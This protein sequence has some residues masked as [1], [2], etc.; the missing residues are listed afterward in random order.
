MSLV[1]D[2]DKSNAAHVQGLH[3]YWHVELRNGESRDQFADD[4]VGTTQEQSLQGIKM[5]RKSLDDPFYGTMVFLGVKMG[6]WIPAFA[7]GQ[8]FK[9]TLEEETD[10]LVLYRKTYTGSSGFSYRAYVIG[11]RWE[12]DGSPI[13]HTWSICPPCFMPPRWKGDNV[14]YPGGIS[15]TLDPLAKNH[16]DQWTETENYGK[17]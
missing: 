8:V 5:L 16:F 10:G 4:S 12:R 13:E 2:F 9:V 1:T 15:E 17:F 3:F 11:R 14:R 7:E 6:A